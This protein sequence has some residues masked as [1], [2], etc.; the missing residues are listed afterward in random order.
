V[1]VP[2]AVGGAVVGARSAT[3]GEDAALLGVGFA[4]SL[5]AGRAS[6]ENPD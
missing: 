5:R 4:D 1:P 3:I 2:A 6:L